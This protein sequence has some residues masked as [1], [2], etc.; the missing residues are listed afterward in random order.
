MGEIAY[1]YNLI[2]DNN[3][4][5]IFVKSGKYFGYARLQIGEFSVSRS[6]SCYDYKVI[7][8]RNDCQL[9]PENFPQTAF[10][11]VPDCRTPDLPANSETESAV[12]QIIGQSVNNNEF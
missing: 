7:S 11:P 1:L 2:M 5:F 3:S 4:V 12:K 10:N 9:F 8:Q 6:S